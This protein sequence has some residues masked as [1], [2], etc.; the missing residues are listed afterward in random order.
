MG[1][2]AERGMSMLPQRRPR[3]GRGGHVRLVATPH[4]ILDMT[5]ES[6]VDLCRRTSFCLVVVARRVGL[7]VR[8]VVQTFWFKCGVSLS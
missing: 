5:M 6:V 3:V 8:P 1:E 7:M 2:V 4:H